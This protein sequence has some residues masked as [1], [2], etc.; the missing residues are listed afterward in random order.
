MKKSVSLTLL[1][2]FIASLVFAG[3]MIS[4]QTGP[5]PNSG[6]GVPDGSGMDNRIQNGEPGIESPGPAPNSGD[7]VHDGSGF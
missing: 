7:G 3:A 2:I 4:M 6:D 5:V 1:G